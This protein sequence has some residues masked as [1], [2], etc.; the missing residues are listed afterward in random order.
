MMTSYERFKNRLAGLKVDRAPNF[1]I[2]MQ[3][4]AHYIHQP[5]AKYYQDYRIL[6]EANLMVQKAF[7]LDIVQAISDPYREA[8]DLGAQIS[9]PDDTLPVCVQPLLNDE[10]KEE[11]LKMVSPA[12]GPRMSDRIEAIRHFRKTVGGNIPIMGWVEGALAE[13]AVLRGV[14]NLLADLYENPDAIKGLLEFCVELEIAF[15]QAQ[16][17]AGADII[18]LGDAIASQISPTMYEKFALP[19]Q[20]QIFNAI[21]KMGAV[22]RLHICGDTTHLLSLMPQSGAD[23]IDLDWMVNF[24]TAT[25]SFGDGPAPCGNF[26][27]VTILFQGSHEQVRQAVFNCLKQGGNRCF[28]AA[29]CEVVD[30]TPYENL[31]AQVETLSFFECLK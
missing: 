31:L 28:S 7:G 24:E 30:G 12:Q 3:F 8:S 11:R 14:N 13:V 16:V 15:A 5:L 19:Y 2:M 4:A 20:K 23:I 22:C 27:P 6:C 17:A 10:I 29:G 9:F 26:D 25:K 1:N 18:G 21:K